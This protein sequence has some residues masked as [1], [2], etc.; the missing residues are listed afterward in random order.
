ML[1]REGG[2]VGLHEF[3]V[4]FAVGEICLDVVEG[5]FLL[6]WM[7]ETVRLVRVGMDSMRLLVEATPA[8]NS[9]S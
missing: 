3:E 8:M 2:D 9:C 4:A 7:D 1:W 5:Q 6:V